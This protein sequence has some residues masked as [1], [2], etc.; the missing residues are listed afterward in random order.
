MKTLIV[1]VV[2]GL[3][4]VCERP[5]APVNADHS[6]HDHSNANMGSIDHSKM[7]SSPG[8]AS[9]PHELQFIDTMTVHHDGAIE[10]A[11]LVSTRSQRPEM[12]EL[13]KSI[14]DAQRTEVT[15]MKKWR[16][17]WFGNAKPAINMDFPGMHAGMTGMDTKKL[18][19]LKANEFDVEFLRQMIPHHEGAIEM[20][21][22]LKPGDSYPELKHLSEAIIREQSAEIA[23]MKTWLLVW[24]VT[25]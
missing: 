20:A 11:M 18:E 10:M 5:P 24:A 14:I 3:L 15:E 4:A 1:I 2:F 21:K 23:K 22:A 19:M 25:K 13:A 16:S 8:A 9:A 7:E 6:L 17:K 12:K